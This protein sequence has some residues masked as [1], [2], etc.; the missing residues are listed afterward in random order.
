MAN[1]FCWLGKY[2]TSLAPLAGGFLGI[3]V[4]VSGISNNLILEDAESVIK[5]K[6]VEVPQEVTTLGFTG[7]RVLF[8]T[9][10]GL[11]AGLAVSNRF[12]ERNKSQQKN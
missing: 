3:L 6:L 5:T 7:L 10:A 2:L 12:D 9:Y 11:S 8:L 1:K 4:G